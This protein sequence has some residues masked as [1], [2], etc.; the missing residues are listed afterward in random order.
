MLLECFKMHPLYITTPIY[1]VN[2]KPHIGHAYTTIVCDIFVRFN[3]MFGRDVFF[4]TG[5]DEHG[6]KIEQSANNAGIEP[7][8]F[9]DNIS[10]LFKDLLPVL[11]IT[12]DDFIRTTELRHKNAVTHFWSR[13]K[14]SGH[15]YLGEYSG[16]YDIRNEAYFSEDELVDGRSPLGGNVHYMT[17]ECYFFKLSEFQDKLLNFYEQNPDFIFPMQRRNEVLSFVKRGLNDLAISRTTFSWGIPVPN[18]PKHVIY[19]WLD[20]LTNYLTLNGYPDVDQANNERWQN[21]IHFVGK[22]IVRFHAVYWPAFLMAA[23]LP[24]PRQIVSHGW[25]LSEGEKM[26][27]SVGN[28]QD[29]IK[30]CKLFGSDALRYF[31]LRELSFGEDGNFSLAGFIGRYNA[32]L[33]NAYGN[34]CSRVFSFVLKNCDGSVKRPPTL[35]GDDQLFVAAVD[36]ELRESV[37]LFQRYAFSKYLEH[38]EHAMSL[39]NQYMDSQKPW[40][41]RTSDRDRMEEALFWMVEQIYKITRLFY[42]VIP[43]CAEKVFNQLG[44][45]MND[46]MSLSGAVPDEFHIREIETLFPR[47]DQ[48]SDDFDVFSDD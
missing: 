26:S 33:A 9:T 45:A 28:V 31:L 7:Q 23:D 3:R 10:Q 41:L 34:L 44:I 42:P 19:V 21:V 12:N 17:E 47:I 22:E 14:E 38:L 20:A 46:A 27:K 40:A 35:T 43:I 29:P 4:S 13:L 30:Y 39:A 36:S 6:K 2:A 25:W 1:Y 24:P 37:S 5:T 48:F 8:L 18:D 16:W 15:I 11:N 32:V